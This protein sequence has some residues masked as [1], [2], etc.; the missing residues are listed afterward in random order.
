ML[1]DA[2]GSGESGAAAYR[3]GHRANWSLVALHV[4]LVAELAD[5]SPAEV[6]GCPLKSL[7][8]PAATFVGST[9]SS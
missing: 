3:V 6:V 5:T 7:L 9:G 4:D 1:L 2:V 8:S